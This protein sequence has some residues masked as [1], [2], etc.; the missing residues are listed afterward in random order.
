MDQPEYMDNETFPAKLLLFGEYGVLLGSAAL[1]VPLSIFTGKF[2][3]HF[4][5]GTVGEKSNTELKK[6]RDYLIKND[7]NEFDLAS[8]SND[9]ENGLYFSSTIPNQYGLGSSGALVAAFYY[10]YAQNAINRNETNAEL[11]NLLKTKLSAIESFFHQKSSGLDPLVSYLNRPVLVSN[12]I[13]KTVNLPQSGMNIFLIDSKTKG[14][15]GKNVNNFL[16]IIENEDTRQIMDTEY[17]TLINNSI[18][19][20]L[21]ENES[22]FIL[23]LKKLSQFQCKYFAPMFG[24]EYIAL[25]QHGMETNNYILKLCGSGGGGFVLGFSRKAAAPHWFPNKR[26]ITT[27]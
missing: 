11:I 27:N 19:S 24:N 9:I 2:M 20:F 6:L 17:K 25:A 7:F 16:K 23:N 15:T 22:D 18:N 21:I 8:F 10:K 5:P 3:A 1:S 12:H 14:N 4:Q 26:I 13:V